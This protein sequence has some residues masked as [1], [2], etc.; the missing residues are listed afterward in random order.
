MSCSTR[1]V[2]MRKTL[3]CVSVLSWTWNTKTLLSHTTRVNPYV[4]FTSVCGKEFAFQPHGSRFNPTV[5]IFHCC[6]RLTEAL[7][8]GFCRWKLKETCHMHSLCMCVNFFP[9][10]TKESLQSSKSSQNSTW[11][12]K[13]YQLL[14]HTARVNPYV[15]FTIWNNISYCS[16]GIILL[17]R[18][19]SCLH[20]KKHTSSFDN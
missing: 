15:H 12:G 7:W 11:N 18:L 20:W 5:S 16:Q 10:K 3:V 9:R 17:T 6:L 2:V 1:I 4:H 8:G 14:S 19:R 13:F